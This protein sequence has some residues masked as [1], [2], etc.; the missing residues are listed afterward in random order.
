[1]MTNKDLIKTLQQY[2]ENKP[3]YVQANTNDWLCFSRV[4]AAHEDDVSINLF[5]AGEPS[6]KPM[7][8]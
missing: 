2:S 3:V 4:L 7:E 8:Q 6:I 5:I 1:M